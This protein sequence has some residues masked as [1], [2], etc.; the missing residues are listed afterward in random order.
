MITE[1]NK[2]SFGSIV[3]L[4]KTVPSYQRDFVWNQDDVTD[5]IDSLFD[6]SNENREFYFCGSMVLFQN[7]DKIYE[8]VD[9]Q[10][11]SI[12]IH[13][14]VSHLFNSL[15]DQTDI[16]FFKYSTVC[17][18]DFEEKVT[19][20]FS[21]SEK[22]I[23]YFLSAVSDGTAIRPST[24]NDSAILK[25]LYDC[26][27]GIKSF[28]DDKLKSKKEI[29]KFLAFILDK[30]FVIHYLCFEMADALLTYSRL[31][32]GGK[33]LGHLEIVKGMLYSSVEKKGL[34]WEKFEIKW[35]KFWNQIVE[36]K[37]IGGMDKKKIIIKQDQFL[38]YFF[39]THFPEIVNSACDVKD[40]FTPE[41][42][43][44]YF[45]QSDEAKAN[46]YNNPNE[47]ID[48]LENTIEKIVNMRVGQHADDKIKKFYIEIATLSQSQTQP[49]M[50]M[51]AISDSSILQKE[52]LEY[53]YK[54]IFIFTTSVSGSGSTSGVWKNLAKL[55]RELKKLND[56]QIAN[57]LK[58]Q[59]YKS[60]EFYY[61][62]NFLEYLN[63]ENIFIDTSKLKKTLR[64]L[65]IFMRRITGCKDKE[66]YADWYISRH[67][68]VDHLNPKASAIDAGDKINT[69]GNS[70]LLNTSVN[71][72]LKDTAFD[73]AKKL[74]AYKKS[75]FFHGR[76]IVSDEKD[77][78]GVHKKLVK[79]MNTQT[80]MNDIEI[81]E[82][83][84]DIQK[85]FENYLLTK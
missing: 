19:Y 64:N 69:I 16:D 68:D 5:F 10:Q 13:T 54:L 1:N 83:S 62:N 23:N 49:L 45:L 51:L 32:T 3:K 73:N 22:N 74:N 70:S 37:S 38:T 27:E 17:S 35:E 44:S 6:A 85:I 39:L 28:V 78:N 15:P 60:I 41:K 25:S 75:E 84:S 33:P 53:V 77:E 47:F 29:K 66:N 4:P 20:N 40:G 43:L 52:L 26:S 57:E 21:H 9:G 80:K 11:R 7:S 24:A 31:N 81:I 61:K 59:I 65:E 63:K 14:L 58:N 76:A 42:K 50:F 34:N 48:L 36:L 71:K 67:I 46:F 12:V 55:T 82:R 56:N 30:V 72:G 18:K 8:V 79:L 2:T